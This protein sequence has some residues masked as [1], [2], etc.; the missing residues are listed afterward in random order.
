M[1]AFDGFIAAIASELKI[2]FRKKAEGQYTANVEFDNN[3]HQDV[4]VAIDNDEAGDKILRYYA[5]IG[6]VNTE[7]KNIYKKALLV[8]AKLDYGSIA[9]IENS[10]VL[11]NSMVLKDCECDPESFIKSL[12]YSAA[13]ADEL[14]ELFMG[15]DLH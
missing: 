12:F 14:E 8:N 13:K 10:L 9:L 3:R 4:L 6:K 5:L 15:T 2:P 11:C 1:Q 7:D